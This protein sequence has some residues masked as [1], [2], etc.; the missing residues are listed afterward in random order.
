M[1]RWA[2]NP[3]KRSVLHD[4]HHLPQCPPVCKLPALYVI[5]SIVKNVGDP[6]R[7]M[8]APRLAEVRRAAV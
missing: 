6:Y 8:F 4:R 3:L 7:M 5:D 2:P 1:L